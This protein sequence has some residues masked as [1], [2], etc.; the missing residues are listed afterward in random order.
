MEH[1][2]SIRELKEDTQV[3][4]FIRERIGESSDK[5]GVGISYFRPIVRGNFSVK[6]SISEHD[7]AGR[8]IYT[9]RLEAVEDTQWLTLLHAVSAATQIVD[10]LSVVE[11]QHAVPVQGHIQLRVPANGSQVI[12]TRQRDLNAFV[13][14]LADVLDNASESRRAG[15]RSTQQ[16]VFGLLIIIVGSQQQPVFE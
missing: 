12:L 4:S 3:K 10:R 8:R 2:V 6:V 7:V 15:K 9:E 1:I 13:L 11:L 16:E 14:E 5:I